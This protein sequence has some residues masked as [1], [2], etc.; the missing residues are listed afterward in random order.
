MRALWVIF[1]SLKD[2]T[3]ESYR[4]KNQ[5][6]TKRKIPP[7]TTSKEAIANLSSYFK[8]MTEQKLYLPNLMFLCS[9]LETWPKLYLRTEPGVLPSAFILSSKAWILTWSFSW[10]SLAGSVVLAS[11]PFSGKPTSALVFLLKEERPW[12]ACHPCPWKQRDFIPPPL[13]GN[14]NSTG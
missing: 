13:S 14:E 8:M 2:R 3:S 1:N 7:N 5:S 4:L 11:P 10:F 12:A 9:S 6:K